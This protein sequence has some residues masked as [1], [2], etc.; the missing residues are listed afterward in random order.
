ML[1][2][3]FQMNTWVPA[4]HPSRG[5][6]TPCPLGWVSFGEGV[7]NVVCPEEDSGR[8]GDRS[9]RL[10]SSSGVHGPDR[11]P[12]ACP[13]SP[14]HRHGRRRCELLVLLPVT[15]FRDLT[16]EPRVRPHDRTQGGPVPMEPSQVAQE[17]QVTGGRGSRGGG[18]C[19]GAAW[20]P[21]EEL[22]AMQYFLL[23]LP[24]PTCWC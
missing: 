24:V 17:A 3:N 23:D 5:R 22:G 13:P 19:H 18:G 2:T 6:H 14:T 10:H 8:S 16:E 4:G 9:D 20:A 21:G 11:T 7:P 1:E 15:V 12:P